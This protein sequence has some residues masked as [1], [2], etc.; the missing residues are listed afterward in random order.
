[1]GQ[2]HKTVNLDKKEYLH[3]HKFGCGLKLVEQIGFEAST[4]DILFLLLASS[5]GRGGG[6]LDIEWAGRW[7]GDRIAVIGDY[8]EPDD[9]PGVD[10]K[11]I[12]RA[13]TAD[14]PSDPEWTDI[15]DELVAELNRVYEFNLDVNEKVGWRHR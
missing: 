3:A 7:A 15:S 1:V 8:S 10:A 13:I 9:I 14:E 5:D 11:A 2:Y 6:D 12:Y 4:A